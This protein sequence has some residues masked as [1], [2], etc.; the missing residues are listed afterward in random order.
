MIVSILIAIDILLA[1][2]LLA[3]WRSKWQY[4][5]WLMLYLGGCYINAGCVNILAIAARL[6]GIDNALQWVALIAALVLLV[7]GL[8]ASGG[9]A[10]KYAELRRLRA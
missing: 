5:R 8:L 10:R 9:E 7:V 4:P 1:A 3:G 6:T 2:S